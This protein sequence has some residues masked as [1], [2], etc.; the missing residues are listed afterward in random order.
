[1]LYNKMS[2]FFNADASNFS[3]VSN[4]SFHDIAEMIITENATPALWFYAAGG[5]ILITLALNKILVNSENPGNMHYRISQLVH[6][7]DT[8]LRIRR[9]SVH[10]YENTHTCGSDS[11]KVTI[12]FEFEYGASDSMSNTIQSF[13]ILKEL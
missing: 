3:V 9:I 7:V 6:S 8:F 12:A 1:M 5:M 13:R 4:S 10:R 2:V 11:F